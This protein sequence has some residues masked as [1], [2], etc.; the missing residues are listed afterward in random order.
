MKLLLYTFPFVTWFGYFIY[1]A[2]GQ[3]QVTEHMQPIEH[4][5]TWPGASELRIEL[6]KDEINYEYAVHQVRVL[7][8]QGNELIS[9]EFG[10]D[11]DWRGGSGFIAAMPVD[12]DPPLELVFSSAGRTMLDDPKFN[13]YLDY[14]ENGINELPIS[15]IDPK[16]KQRIADW[17]AYDSSNIG[18]AFILMAF[19][20][21]YYVIFL[22]IVGIVRAVLRKAAKPAEEPH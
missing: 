7:D 13:F 2:I 22:P 20:L 5:Q 21:F 6:S 19:T 11:R 1:V 16:I 10:I 18:P 15:G 14:G 12:D 9:K 3:G 17:Y 8:K 4:L